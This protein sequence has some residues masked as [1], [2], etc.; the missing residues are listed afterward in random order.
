[1]TK[2][3]KVDSIDFQLKSLQ[4]LESQFNV[5]YPDTERATYNSK[6]NYKQ[7]LT[8][9]FQQWSNYKEGYSV[10]LNEEIF[11][12]NGLTPGTPEVKILD[13]F[14]GSGTT[15]YAAKIWG[16]ESI[17]FEVNPFSHLYSL[18][19]TRNYSSSDISDLRDLIL[20]LS[21]VNSE[22][23]RGQSFPLPG[24]KMADK[25]FSEPVLRALKVVDDLN[26]GVSNERVRDL[27][28]FA[29]VANLEGL[30]GYRKAGNGLKKLKKARTDT[31]IHAVDAIVKTL[32]T[33]EK[34]LTDHFRTGPEPKLILSSSQE[35]ESVT[36][37]SV[38][39]I[40]FSP[41]YANCFDY[42]EI[43]KLEL[44]FGGFVKNREEL[45]SIRQSS[46]SSHL[47]KKFSTIEPEQE[48]APFLE[49]LK[50]VELWD[51]KI[52]TML[53]GYFSE[54]KSVL[55]ECFRVLKARG[56][57]SIVVSN[58]NYGGI[59]IPTDLILAS[60]AKGIGFEVES[61][62]VVRWVITSSQQYEKTLPLKKYIRETIIHLKKKED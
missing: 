45:R 31:F 62:E 57:C 9:P 3:E 44:W 8:E 28:R 26:S 25:V 23:A 49:Q 56:F 60:L 52:P 17:G 42:S 59:V 2:F 19:K 54:M 47:N 16:F 18:V 36:D 30:S 41:P 61:L 55:L 21:R 40:I 50:S 29:W 34:D 22:D 43:Y 20:K 7:G 11:R 38:D 33:I 12:R 27:A 5:D 10:S 58:S 13:P 51:K 1:M 37:C 46:L 14:S 35:F 32:K 4:D 24:L 6:V 39:G 48:L 15:P 53:I